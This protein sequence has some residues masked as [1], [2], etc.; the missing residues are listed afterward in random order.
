MEHS[1]AQDACFTHFCHG[2]RS[3]WRRN[4]PAAC[5]RSEDARLHGLLC[6]APVQRCNQPHLLKNATPRSIPRPLANDMRKK[7]ERE[8]TK[9][10]SRTT[11]VELRSRSWRELNCFCC[12][13]LC[14]GPKKTS[15]PHLAVQ[16]SPAVREALASHRPVVA[17]ESTIIA[18]GRCSQS[19]SLLRELYSSWSAQLSAQACPTRRTCRPRCKWRRSSNE[20]VPPLPRSPSSGASHA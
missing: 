12:V 9:R 16:L 8:R 7:R 10:E 11:N 13:V 5:A 1:F 15:M 17:L 4:W 19:N 2:S 18:H 14:M 6:I 20:M 3:K